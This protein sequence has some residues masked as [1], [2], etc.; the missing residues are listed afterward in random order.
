MN[1]GPIRGIFTPNMIPYDAHGGINEAELRRIVDWLIQKGISGIYPNGSTGEFTRFSFDE[2]KRIVQIVA[3]QAAGRVPVLAGAAEANIQ[4]ALEA[5]EYYAKLGC[6]AAAICA[7]YYYKLSQDSVHEYFAELARQSP[8]D[9]VLYNIPIFANE[10]SIDV[11]ARLAQEY[12]RIVGIK[13]S[14]RD[15]PRFLNLINQI[16]PKRPDFSFLIGTEEILMPA[17]LMGAHG[18]TIATSGVVPE[19]IMKLYNLTLQ[20]K[21]DEARQIQFKMLDLI[22]VMLFDIEFPEGFR[23][24][25]ALRGFQMGESR[26][27]LSPKSKPDVEAVSRAL[28]CILSEHG[29]AE[30]PV[31]GCP[32]PAWE[33]QSSQIARVVA[34]VV[35]QMRAQGEI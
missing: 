20:G 18:G 34:E 24:G 35:R 19:V 28:Q 8:L 27:K 12:P 6:R 4:M 13:D 2:R 17:L 21:L 22:N 7:P 26:Q 15:L 30:E 5:C 25:V 16:A 10:I 31:G 1:H 33:P 11:V 9:I 32:V 29:F 3:D 23:A 14:S